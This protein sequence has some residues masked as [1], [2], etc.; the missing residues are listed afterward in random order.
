MSTDTVL[1]LGAVVRATDGSVGKLVRLIVDPETRALTH[2]VVEPA[3]HRRPDHLV[4]LDVVAASDDHVTLRCTAAEFERLAQAEESRLEP[5]PGEG[6][7]YRRRDIVSSPPFYV[8]AAG[9][10]VDL[11][12]SAD[13]GERLV[14]K[15]RDTVLVTRDVVP[16]GEE[17]LC[18]GQRVLATDGDVGHLRGLVV[19]ERSLVVGVLV[20]LG[21]LPTRR[22]AVPM[23]VVTAFGE[24]IEIGLSRDQLR[25]VAEAQDRAARGGEGPG[26]SF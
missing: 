10:S 15:G 16:A 2:L 22:A 14:A 4:P 11:G 25:A 5:A 17:E 23:A 26:P 1:L 9:R 18:S 13:H 3:H 8:L 24:T 12:L 20:G 21:H 7:I 6:R 19:G